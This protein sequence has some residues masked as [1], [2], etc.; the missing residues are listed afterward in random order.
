MFHLRR[1]LDILWHF[2]LWEK[3]FLWREKRQTE[4]FHFDVARNCFSITT[5]IYLFQFA[6][7]TLTVWNERKTVNKKAIKMTQETWTG[8]STVLVY[9]VEPLKKYSQGIFNVFDWLSG[10]LICLS[11]LI[12]FMFSVIVIIVDYIDLIWY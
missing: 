6:S 11:C 5:K 1:C 8:I 12:V 9:F 3:C 4:K 10:W 2:K 7:L